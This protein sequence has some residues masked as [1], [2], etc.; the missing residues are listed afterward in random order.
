MALLGVG[1][2]DPSYS[3]GGFWV[4]RSLPMEAVHGRAMALCAGDPAVHLQH[5][6]RETW[7]AEAC[8]HSLLLVFAPCSGLLVVAGWHG[9]DCSISCPSGTWG[10]SCNLTCQCLN[11]GACNTL[12]GTCTCAPGWRGEKCE[13]PCQVRLNQRPSSEACRVLA[14]GCSFPDFPCASVN[15]MKPL[16]E[17][18]SLNSHG[19]YGWKRGRRG[20][21][22]GGSARIT[23]FFSFISAL[24]PTPTPTALS[25]FLHS[26]LPI[27]LWQPVNSICQTPSVYL[28]TPPILC[29]HYHGNPA[30]SGVESGRGLKG[31]GDRRHRNARQ[32]G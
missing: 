12:D 11:G 2:L 30:A 18:R 1:I 28:S 10:F 21:Q 5:V 27:F 16:E 19:P 13:L 14:R 32:D 9:V 22:L 25:C 15:P 4:P 31:G 6:Y 8:P 29:F 20:N 26:H 7:L 17:L 23:P 3:K 24:V